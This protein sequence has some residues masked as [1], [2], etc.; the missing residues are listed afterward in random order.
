MKTLEGT[1]NSPSGPVK[2][3]PGR[4]KAIR[5]TLK[6]LHRQGLTWKKIGAICNRSEPW[7]CRVASGRYNLIEPVV[8]EVETLLPAPPWETYNQLDSLVLVLLVVTA[9]RQTGKDMARICGTCDRTIRGSIKR[10]R[11]AGHNISASLR[12]PR[13]YRLEE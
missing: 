9:K 12:S 5:R 8:E 3:L 2:A 1:Q 6:M 10:L 4:I 13:G 7:A 11:E